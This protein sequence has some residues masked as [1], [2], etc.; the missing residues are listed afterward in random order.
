MNA[1]KLEELIQ[2]MVSMGDSNKAEKKAKKFNIHAENTLGLYQSDIDELA[3]RVSRDTTIAIGL[4]DSGYYEGKLVCAKSF[5]PKELTP[6]LMETWVKDFDNWEITDS[7]CL[8]L[9]AKSKHCLPKIVEWAD[10]PEEFVKR[11]AFAMMAAYCMTDKKANNDVYEGFYP[12]ILNHV[13]DDRHYV[14]MSI[15]WALRSIGKR[16]QDL[17]HSAIKL[18]K[19]IDAINHKTASWIAKQVIYELTNP[20]VRTSDYPRSIYRTK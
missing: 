2:L 19:T 18:A 5:P 1:P 14:K 16:N 13:I 11:S 8:K 4:Y 10:R 3:K 12:L 7:F 17:R 20:N 15:S 6:Q 9:F